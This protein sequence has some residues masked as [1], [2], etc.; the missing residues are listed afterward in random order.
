MKYGKL[1]PYLFVLPTI[2]GLIVF[3]LGPVAVAIGAS[4]TRW[5]IQTPPKFL[6]LNNFVELVSSET[7]WLIFKNTILFTVI[8]VPGVMIVSLL[9]AVM[10]NQKL[11]GIA[12]FRGLYF[13]PYITA[14]V[15]VAMV[16]NWIFAT[17]FGVLNYVLINF[18]YISDPP[19]WLADKTWALPA[20][21]IVAIWKQVGFQML[22]FLAGLQSIPGSLYDAAAID[23]ANRQQQFFKITLPLLS[24]ITFF[25]FII[26]VIEAFKT[27]EVTFAMTEGGPNNA[28]STLAFYIYQNAFI[29]GRMGFASA[30]ALFLLLFVGLTTLLSFKLKGRMVEYAV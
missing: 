16:W 22:I 14:M 5:N 28:S 21:A 29:F 3:R 13:M 1:T 26:T 4:F 8:F 6:G 30:L 23:G 9:M 7:F 19:A 27:F 10:V 15:A 25:I 24:P 2:V 17:R 12:F 20:L 18:F 11:R